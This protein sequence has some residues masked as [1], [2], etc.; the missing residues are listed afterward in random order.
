MDN[1]GKRESNN[2]QLKP[3][4]IQ[5]FLRTRTSRKDNRDIVRDLLRGVGVDAM[6]AAAGRNGVAA[7]LSGFDDSP[8]RIDPDPGRYAAAFSRLLGTAA[9]RSSRPSPMLDWQASD[10]DLLV[11]PNAG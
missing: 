7:A 10:L 1:K 9:E 11:R 6:A 4:V 5:E 8:D 2:G 3:A